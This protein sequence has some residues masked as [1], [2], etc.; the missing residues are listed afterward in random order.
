MEIQRIHSTM[1]RRVNAVAIDEAQV[2]PHGETKIQLSQIL[3]VYN[4]RDFSE[5]L[6]ASVTIATVYHADIDKWREE[7]RRDS[8][9]I[10][11]DWHSAATPKDLA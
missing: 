4:P 1:R 9:I 2:Q 11:N 8:S 5:R 3:C 7:K 6:V 10:T